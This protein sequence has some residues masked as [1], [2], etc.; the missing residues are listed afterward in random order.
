[1]SHSGGSGLSRTL[2]NVFITWAPFHG[3]TTG[4]HLSHHG[5]SDIPGRLNSIDYELTHYAQSRSWAMVSL[6]RRAVV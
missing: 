4:T 1:M 2:H 5:V 3:A 6:T